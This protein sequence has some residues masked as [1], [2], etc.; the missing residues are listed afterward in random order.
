MNHL[1]NLQHLKFFFDT[2][3]CKSVSEAAKINFVTQSAVSQ[4]ISKL[5][6]LFGHTLLYFN[7][8]SLELTPEGRILF[9]HAGQIFKSVGETYK[10]MLQVR[11]GVQGVVHF[12]TLKSLGMTLIPEVLSRIEKETPG[13]EL[14]FRMG[15]ANL[16]RAALKEGDAEFAITV[17]GDL[18]EGFEKLVLKK[19]RMRLYISKFFE[20]NSTE[21]NR[22]Y[23]DRR[24][25]LFVSDLAKVLH[26]SGRKCELKSFNAG[27]DFTARLADLGYGIGFFPDFLAD[28]ERYPGLKEHL[29]PLPEFEYSIVA[30]YNR[31]TNLSLTAKAFLDR[32]YCDRK[33]WTRICV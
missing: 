10:K 21:I 12:A 19:G 3:Q 20:K 27:W 17:D 28:T 16:I 23:V 32:L 31:G 30:I 7:R 25:G 33:H 5:E 4:G 13:L 8:Q 6:K 9:E 1:F 18:F 2:V 26:Q 11:G 24:E 14:N 29:F 22:V 15:G